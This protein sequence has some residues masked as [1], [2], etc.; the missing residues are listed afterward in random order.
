MRPTQA[1]FAGVTLTAVAEL[2]GN[3]VGGWLS[4][5]YGRKPALV[6]SF[7]GVKIR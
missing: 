4:A 5:R 6:W 1:E 3:W 7:G 2:P